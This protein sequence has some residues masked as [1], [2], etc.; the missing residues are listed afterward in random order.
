MNLQA[1][2][3]LFDGRCIDQHCG[4]NNNRSKLRRYSVTQ[5]QSRQKYAADLP[6]NQAINDCDG[7]IR[8]WY[9]TNNP[10]D[11]KSPTPNARMTDYN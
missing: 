8:G 2:D 7:H 11:T 9:K 6:C 1:L 5:F 10:Q 4:H 3:M